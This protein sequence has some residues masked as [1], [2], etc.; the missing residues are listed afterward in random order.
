M[1]LSPPILLGLLSLPIL[2][3]VLVLYLRR[4][5]GERSVR[6]VVEQIGQRLNPDDLPFRQPPTGL[7]AQRFAEFYRLVARADL[8]V[9]ALLA[10]RGHG[11]VDL[12]EKLGAA[13]QSL[14]EI[15]EFEA[16]Q[17]TSNRVEWRSAELLSL[18]EL[19]DGLLGESMPEREADGAEPD[20]ARPADGA[21]WGR[22]A[23]SLRRLRS[24]L[25]QEFATT[26]MRDLD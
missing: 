1:E 16:Q 3:V 2:L 12:D 5:W 22:V 26:E 4:R 17:R 18:L 20:L 10:R 11:G 21:A 7:G 15:V 19:S 13:R 6:R 9:G 25:R 8:K 14:R 24:Q 23:E